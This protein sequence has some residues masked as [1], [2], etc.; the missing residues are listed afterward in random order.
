[1]FKKEL[2]KKCGKKL[3][4]KH[5]FCPSCGTPINSNNQNWGMLGKNDYILEQD[6]F[7]GLSHNLFGGISGKMFNKMLGGAMKMLENEMKKEINNKDK[8]LKTNFE[9]YV[10]GKKISPENIKVTRNP[11]SKKQEKKTNPQIFLPSGNL[12]KFSTL[13]RQEPTTNIRRLSDKVI[14]EINV[15]GVKSIKD[16]QIVK[17]ENSI[18]IKAVAENQ[19]YNKIIAIDL[20]IQKYKLDKEKIILELGVKN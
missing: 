5:N 10:N 7:G 2:C 12:K 9:L 18:E 11:M 6:S 13:P 19:A 14:Y 20:P 1:M 16:I 4:S 8:Q 17:L 3:N 15:P